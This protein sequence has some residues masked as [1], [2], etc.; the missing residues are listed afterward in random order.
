MPTALIITGM[1]TQPLTRRNDRDVSYRDSVASERCP[2][3]ESPHTKP[4][5]PLPKRRNTTSFVDI[6]D[7]NTDE[8]RGQFQVGKRMKLSSRNVRVVNILRQSM[9]IWIYP[10]RTRGITPV[11]YNIDAVVETTL[12][13]YM[14]NASTKNFQKPVRLKVKYVQRF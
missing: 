14:G 12:D 7:D 10:L 11:E 5:N 3:L 1:E 9:I 8:I 4:L 2:D 13:E 6:V